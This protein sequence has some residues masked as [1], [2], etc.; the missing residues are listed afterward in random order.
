VLYCKVLLSDLRALYCCSC[1]E[2]V[3][4]ILVCTVHSR[5]RPFLTRAPFL[6]YVRVSFPL[7]KKCILNNVERYAVKCRL[8]WPVCVPVSPIKPWKFPLPGANSNRD[9]DWNHDL[10]A[11]GNLIWRIKIRFNWLRFDLKY[12]QLKL[13]KDLNRG[14]SA[15]CLPTQNSAIVSAHRAQLIGL[16]EPSNCFY[17]GCSLTP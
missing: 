13:K 3:L 17:F 11:F 2:S 4:I 16:R 14:K 5:S 10:N 1:A 9:W 8:R 7:S 12:L 6:S 15:A